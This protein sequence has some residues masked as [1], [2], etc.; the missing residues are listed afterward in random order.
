MNLRSPRWR[1]PTLFAVGVCLIGAL[2]PSER[3]PCQAPQLELRIDYDRSFIVA[4]TGKAGLLGFLGHKHGVLATSWEA[5]LRYN[6]EAVEGS[7]IRVGVDVAALVIDTDVARRRARL[8][9]GPTDEE[10][11]ELQPKMLDNE[12]LAAETHAAIEF[13]S[14]SVERRGESE[15]RVVGTF[16]LMG[17]SRDV[18]VDITAW[19]T[20]GYQIFS[21]EFEIGQR[22]YGLEPE[23]VGGVVKV[24]NDVTIRFQIWT[25]P[26][27]TVRR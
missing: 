10:R 20:A 25:L 7:T 24:A 13:A 17:V 11:A 22:D 23:S 4:S 6:T 26:A 2:P 27:E 9:A 21:G 8:G 1:T 16:T 5:E 3:S 19:S 12:H 15:L 18:E 14:S